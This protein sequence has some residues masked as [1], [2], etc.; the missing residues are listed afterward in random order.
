MW[1]W[2]I[3]GTISRNECNGNNWTQW[4]CNSHNS[5]VLLELKWTRFHGMPRAGHRCI[6][7]WWWALMGTM[8]IT[9]IETV[10]NRWWQ[11]LAVY[12]QPNGAQHWWMAFCDDSFIVLLSFSR[13]ATL[14]TQGT[15]LV[16]RSCSYSSDAW[17]TTSSIPTSLR[18]SSSSCP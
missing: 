6:N 12:M 9:E 1:N 14:G 17:V 15:S 2:I 18:V 8:T 5:R 11:T 4:K 16:W 3:T 7:R 10:R 13:M